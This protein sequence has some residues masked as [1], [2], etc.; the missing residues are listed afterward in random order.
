MQ[1]KWDRKQTK[2]L[3]SDSSQSHSSDSRPILQIAKGKRH[4]NSDNQR[5][6]YNKRVSEK[7]L[8]LL[9]GCVILVGLLVTMYVFYVRKNQKNPI[10]DTTKQDL[11][12]SSNDENNINTV[13]D[14]YGKSYVESER[15]IASDPASWNKET[16]DEAYFVLM[17]A[18][19]I[20]AFSQVY[21]SLAKIDLAKKSGLN[22]DNNSY[23][24]NQTIRDSIRRRAD[25]NA[26][27]ALDDQDGATR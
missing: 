23:G 27:K 26:N 7:K 13:V 18:D 24:I 20:S 17:Y 11:L 14:R 1:I 15:S 9:F 6:I 22:I 25:A 10:Y 21:D 19:K 2:S 12:A 4:N 3:A 16:L 8:L 5:K